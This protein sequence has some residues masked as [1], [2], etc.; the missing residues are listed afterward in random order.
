MS[1]PSAIEVWKI[2]DIVG[3]EGNRPSG[4]GDLTG[5]AE[6]IKKV[7]VLQPIIGVEE[8]GRITIIAGHR[9]HAAAKLAGLEEIEVIVLDDLSDAQLK[10]MRLIEN[11]H[12]EDLQ[13][14]DKAHGFKELADWLTPTA[15]AISATVSKHLSLL[16]LPE[17]AQGWVA[18]GKLPQDQAVKMA[19][20]APETQDQLLKHGVPAGWEINQAVRA[21]DQAKRRKAIIAEADATGVKVV[22]ERYGVWPSDEDV[23][24]REIARYGELSHVDPQE[25]AGLDCH[26]IWVSPSGDT[27]PYCTEPANHPKPD[28]SGEVT[29]REVVSPEEAERR[30]E[31][32]TLRAQLAESTAAR[33]EWLRNLVPSTPG[34]MKAALQLQLLADEWGIDGERILELL[35]L[36]PIEG[37]GCH[38]DRMAAALASATTDDQA[39]RAMFLVT[40]SQHEELFECP[41]WMSE[42]RAPAYEADEDGARYLGILETLG[43]R[44]TEI[45]CQ[46]LGIDGPEPSFVPD[47]PAGELD[48]NDYVDRPEPEITIE[49]KKGK[50]FISCTQCGHVGFNT[51]EDVA[52]IRGQVHLSEQHG[53]VA[54]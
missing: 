31:L 5:L 23:V 22:P 41:S 34:L 10:Q 46:W 25:H 3:S 42:F 7:G 27:H 50:F 19:G 14:L 37:A 18:D 16:K 24:M 26:A 30:Q 20:L 2:D 36:D 49:A 12:R 29:I 47:L 4:L 44:R 11:L 39:K 21:A 33:R 38:D 35:G 53:S 15:S 1:D 28:E 52:Q 9:R 54:A 45:E 48:D 8:G 40:V 32:E 17:R 6:S 13:L 51:K 43:Y